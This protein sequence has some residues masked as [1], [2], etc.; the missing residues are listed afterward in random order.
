MSANSRHV[1]ALCVLLGASGCALLGKSDALGPRYFSPEGASSR[2]AAPAPASGLELRLGRI[3]AAPYLGERIVFRDSRYEL[4]FYEE[5]RWTERP[6]SYLR[7][8]LSR[9][10]FEELGVRRIVSG[11]GATLD[12]ELSEFAELRGSRPVA[13]VCATYM[14]YGNRLVRR[15]ATVTV[16]LPIAA[17]SSQRES[18]EPT[19]RAM[20]EAMSLAVQQIVEQVVAELRTSR[21]EERPSVSAQ[22]LTRSGLP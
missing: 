2:V 5:R 1:L 17:S 12:I 10:L 18:P 20:T 16:E 19:V 14:L 3:T 6:E 9:A 13:R 7:R 21:P 22:P 8:A 4:G 11:A 15:E